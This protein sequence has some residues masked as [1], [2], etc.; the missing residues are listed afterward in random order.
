MAPPT[1][2]LNLDVEAISGI[3]GSISVACWVVVFSPQIIE[4]FRRSSAE[5]LSIQFLVV[6]LLGD[7]F[8]ILGAVLQGVLPTMIILAIYYTI[9]DVVLLGQCFYYR[10]FTLRDDVPK[11]QPPKPKRNG[12]ANGSTIVVNGYLGEPNERT[13]LLGAASAGAV[14]ERSPCSYHGAEDRERRGSWSHLSPA[15]PFVSE[16]AEPSPPRAPPTRLQAFAFNSLAILM[17]CAAGVVGWWLSRCYGQRDDAGDRPEDSQDDPLSFNLLGQI[18]GWLCAALYLGSR[19]PQLLLNWRRKST[20]GVSVLFFL[21]ACLGNLTYVL[22]ILAYDPQCEGEEG[23][24]PGEAAKIFWQYI[25]V[26]LSWLA[27][28]AGTLLL[29]LSIFV[30]FFLYSKIEGDESSDGESTDEEESIEGDTWDDRPVLE[31]NNT[32]T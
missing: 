10:G 11:P 30:Q 20:E 12:D 25:L 14:S 13:G 32:E 15:V 18:F 22:S 8:N 21:F 4:N 31:R 3:C 29:D 26:N 28:S 16:D 2:Q 24:R 27:G 23:C 6:W 9:A 19:L 17:V 1:D 5:G 7:V